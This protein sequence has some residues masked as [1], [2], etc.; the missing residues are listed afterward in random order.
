MLL[1]YVEF[2]LIFHMVKTHFAN[3]HFAPWETKMLRIVCI[4]YSIVF[5]LGKN[6]MSYLATLVTKVQQYLI[7]SLL[8][9]KF[10]EI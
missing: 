4:S 2:M 1:L 7:P 3:Y 9:P 6:S 8:W 5:M 10:L